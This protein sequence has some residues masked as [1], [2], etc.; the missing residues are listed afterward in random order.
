M[1]RSGSMSLFGLPESVLRFLMGISPAVPL[2]TLLLLIVFLIRFGSQAPRP[3]FA[4]GFLL[5]ILIEVCL[6]FAGHPWVWDLSPGV[7]MAMGVTSVGC[8][9][10]VF[11]R[12]LRHHWITAWCA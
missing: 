11:V 5:F 6:V 7:G 10:E 3:M 8:L 1:V 4:W 2:L 9:V 12:R